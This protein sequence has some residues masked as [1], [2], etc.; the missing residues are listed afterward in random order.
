MLLALWALVLFLAHSHALQHVGVQSDDGLQ[1]TPPVAVTSGHQFGNTGDSNQDISDPYEA[2]LLV[3]IEQLEF[4]LRP[5]ERQIVLRI[6]RDAVQSLDNLPF[7]GIQP[8]NS[9]ADVQPTGQRRKCSAKDEGEQMWHLPT[10][11]KGLCDGGIIRS[12]QTRETL[13]DL[14]DRLIALRRE[15]YNRYHPPTRSQIFVQL[16]EPKDVKEGDVWLKG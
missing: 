7:L 5:C 10:T 4:P 8:G 12:D 2:D 11:Y 9:A 14:H 15:V 1:P 13:D 6:L 16:N 3:L